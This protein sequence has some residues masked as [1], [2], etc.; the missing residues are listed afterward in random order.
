MERNLFQVL[1][2][3]LRGYDTSD[4][5]QLLREHVIMISPSK[6]GQY[7][8]ISSNGR[9]K[10]RYMV[11]PIDSN[12]DGEDYQEAMRLGAGNKELSEALKPRGVVIKHFGL[13]HKDTQEYREYLL[14]YLTTSDIR[15][16]ESIVNEFFDKEY[17][18]R[19]KARAENGEVS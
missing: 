19:R 16:V 12:P 6:Y 11:I 10:R 1:V 17:R 4:C 2:N 8:I 13:I 18:E 7:R 5:A 14:T 15:E 3:P 9:T